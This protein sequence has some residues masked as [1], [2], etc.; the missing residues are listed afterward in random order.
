MKTLAKKKS[1]LQWFGFV[2]IFFLLLGCESF[3]P[4]VSEKFID[5][6]I[7]LRLASLEFGDV[8]PDARIK[9]TEILKNNNYTAESFNEYADKI[10]A[11]PELWLLFQQRVV[12]ILDSLSEP[13][14]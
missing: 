8:N 6:Y 7:E 14:K 5:T 13:A 9:R 4:S 2:F 12:D 10:R 11:N 3:S 1:L